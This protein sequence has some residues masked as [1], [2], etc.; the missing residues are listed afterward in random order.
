MIII[1]VHES[2]HCGLF[3][4]SKLLNSRQ[5]ELIPSGYDNRC[6][7]S[8][9]I[10]RC[11][12]SSYNYASE[13][14]KKKYDFVPKKKQ[15]YDDPE[16]YKSEHKQIQDALTH[17]NRVDVSNKLRALFILRKQ[18]DYYPY[19]RLTKKQVND[20]VEN[21]KYIFKRLP[22]RDLDITD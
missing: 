3:E 9:I 10:N 6:V 21:M 12:Y 5:E 8:T 4:F 22:K 15:D 17:Y 16:K 2:P 14:L 11:Y 20:S 1:N 18:A 7:Y 19:N 13:W